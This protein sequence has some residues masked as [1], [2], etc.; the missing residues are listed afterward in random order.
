M[1]NG[2]RLQTSVD[3]YMDYTLGSA[4]LWEMRGNSGVAGKSLGS[5]QHLCLLWH[6]QPPTRRLLNSQAPQCSHNMQRNPSTSPDRSL[7]R[8]SSAT[9]PDRSL[10]RNI[11]RSPED[12]AP[13]ERLERPSNPPE[14][15]LTLLHPTRSPTR[16]FYP[17]QGSSAE[18]TSVDDTQAGRFT[19]A[20]KRVAGVNNVWIPF[21][22]IVRDIQ[23]RLPFYVSD[24]T[25]AWNYRVVP[26]T[27]VSS[28]GV[29][30]S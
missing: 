9:S 14:P 19:A 5:D 13:P 30:S 18:D 24:W 6:R 27:W 26:A 12:Y 23:R 2:G 21:S 22:G 15:P 28:S 8:K 4:H 16:T 25:D 7:R 11:S 1:Q 17:T 10:R 29:S 20:R 3:F